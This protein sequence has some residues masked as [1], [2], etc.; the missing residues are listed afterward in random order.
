[1]NSLQ[2]ILTVVKKT[3]YLYPYFF[4][5]IWRAGFETEKCGSYVGENGV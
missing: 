2:F 4:F 3:T 5:K 1:M